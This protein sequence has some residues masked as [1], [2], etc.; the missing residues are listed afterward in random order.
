MTALTPQDVNKYIATIRINFENAY[1]TQTSEER[2]ILIKSWYEILKEY[3]KE[4]CDKAVINA[5]KYAKFAPRIG[6]VVEQIE[7][8]RTAYEKT[9]SELWTELTGVL[10]SVSKIM[11]FG[12]ARHWYNGKLI[13]P[14][15]EVQK[16][17]EKL[18]PILQNYAGGVSGL[19]A[20]SRQDTLD[21]EKGRFLKSVE[22]L[23]TREKTKQEMPLGLAGI[24]QELSGQMAIEDKTT[25]LLKE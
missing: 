25:K 6:D 2:Q 13:E 24:I 14:M 8:M 17:Y 20:L 18:D 23:R 7:K 16:I 22:I 15:N 4:V 9:D 19:I 12:T 3:P 21:Y 5:I 10:N 11:Y 1:K